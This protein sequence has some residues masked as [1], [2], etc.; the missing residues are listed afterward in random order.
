M[1]MLIREPMCE[2]TV[3]GR[4]SFSTD[5]VA[6]LVREH[7]GLEGV[8]T[9]LPGEWDQNFR[10]D[11]ADETNYVIKIA[12]T[13]ASAE[14]LDFQNQAMQRLND[15]WRPGVSPIVVPSRA[16]EAI[17]TVASPLG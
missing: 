2:F 14:L 15:G 8:F 6:G 5:A 9:L 4:A 13:G 11:V 7:F 16:G 3:T 12:N 17:V 10:L 1:S